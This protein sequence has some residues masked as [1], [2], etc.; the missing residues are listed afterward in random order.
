MSH[1]I[2]TTFSNNLVTNFLFSFDQSSISRT[3]HAILG[4]FLKHLMKKGTASSEQNS[5]ELNE[6]NDNAS[7]NDSVGG[8]GADGDELPVRAATPSDV[9]VNTH[10]HSHSHFSISSNS[11]NNTAPNNKNNSNNAGNPI[12]HQLT[13]TSI[14]ASLILTRLISSL[15][16]IHTMSPPPP[17]HHSL[18]FLHLSI[19]S[20]VLESCAEKSVVGDFF[21]SHGPSTLLQLIDPKFTFE[22]ITRSLRLTKYLCDGGS[23]FKVH[24]CELGLVDKVGSTILDR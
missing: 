10:S 6:I 23:E 22:T 20:L 4:E 7:W 14:H 21:Q 16:V 3:R 5:R 2:R 17:S 12:H 15:R 13:L 9:S 19:V 8:D 24:L 1:H 18:I 11:N